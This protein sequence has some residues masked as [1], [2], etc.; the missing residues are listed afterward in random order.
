MSADVSD[1]VDPSH[2]IVASLIEAIAGIPGIVKGAPAG[3]GDRKRIEESAGC[4][5]EDNAR[6]LVQKLDRALYGDVTSAKTLK[7]ELEAWRDAVTANFS[8]GG[9]AAITSGIERIKKYQDRLDPLVTAAEAQLA[10]ADKKAEETPGTDCEKRAATIYQLVQLISP[11]AR[12]EQIRKLHKAVVDLQTTLRTVYAVDQKWINNSNEFVVKEDIVPTRETVQ[13]VVVKA[14]PVSY[15]ASD[16]SIEVKRGDTVTASFVVRK[17]SRYVPEVGIGATAS[18][19]DRPKYATATDASGKMV[20]AR[21]QNDKVNLDPTVLV[22]FLPQSEEGAAIRM[23]QIGASSSKDSPAV[24]LGMGWRI[25]GGGSG[26][27]AIGVGAAI[28]WV[29][30]LQG[31]AE[32]APITGTKDIEEHV[33]FDLNPRVRPYFNVQYKF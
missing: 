3:G 11:H 5:A 32:G 9:V 22:N 6:E 21:V 18:Y 12:L 13:V 16:A 7:T 1:A 23:W 10:L 27:V 2:L 30:T 25:F 20:V 4:T 26:G 28:A 33:K 19:F 14:T 17:Y 29:K 8:R 15:A 31:L 24:F